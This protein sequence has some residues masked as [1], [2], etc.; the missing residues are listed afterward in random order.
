MDKRYTQEEVMELIKKN[1][2]VFGKDLKKIFG[3][4]VKYIH[5]YD[6]E[7]PFGFGMYYLHVK[8]G[9][10]IF[11]IKVTGKID[12]MRMINEG[13][14]KDLEN[15]IAI[16][17]GEKKVLDESIEGLKKLAESQKLRKLFT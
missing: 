12:K 11:P 2:I 3:E 7:L 15:T 13:D 9:F 8:T 16:Y 5:D 4:M 6:E 17:E 14:I 10:M 1:E